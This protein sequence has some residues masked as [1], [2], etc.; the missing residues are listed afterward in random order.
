MARHQPLQ[1][2]ATAQSLPPAVFMRDRVTMAAM[3]GCQ[4]HEP[5]SLFVRNGRLRGLSLSK[6]TDRRSVEALVMRAYLQ[7]AFVRWDA[8]G[9]RTTSLAEYGSHAVRLTELLSVEGADM[10]CLRLELH[11]KDSTDPIENCTCN[12][13]EATVLAA[14]RFMAEAQK[15]EE[16][17]RTGKSRRDFEL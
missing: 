7:L 6:L 9:A 12:D 8:T 14:E 10:P 15:R 13:L 2:G 1:T 5:M 17:T 4:R 11:G 3:I 16:D